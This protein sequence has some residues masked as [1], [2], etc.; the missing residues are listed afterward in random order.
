M[1][2]IFEKSQDIKYDGGI[3][4]YIR[5]NNKKGE[6]VLKCSIP[7]ILMGL[8]STIVFYIIAKKQ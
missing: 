1:S 2:S 3:S 4:E 8:F 7:Y 6:A 5:K